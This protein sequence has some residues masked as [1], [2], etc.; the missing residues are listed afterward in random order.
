MRKVL[1][2]VCMLM[3]LTS[4]SIC[5]PILGP[6]HRRASSHLK[7]ENAPSRLYR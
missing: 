3:G 6:H 5:R 1:F 4:F 2:G 7:M